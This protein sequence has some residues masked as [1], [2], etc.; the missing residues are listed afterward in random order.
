M[1]LVTFKE[2]EPQ[3]LLTLSFYL[4][5]DQEYLAEHIDADYAKDYIASD[6]VM[7]STLVSPVTHR[8][9][10]VVR[11]LQLDCIG[12]FN[13]IFTNLSRYELLSV[14]RI[15][16]MWLDE[17]PDETIATLINRNSASAV[18][19][20]KMLGFEFYDDHDEETDLYM[21]EAQ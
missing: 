20:A 1:K 18:R 2:Y 21:R 7:S 6:Q 8:I 12:V 19:M 15:L 14:Y 5:P 16:K 3:D 10:G 9:L 11:Y 17:R 4:Q 13:G